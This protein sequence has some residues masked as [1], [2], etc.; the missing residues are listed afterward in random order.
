MIPQTPY[1]AFLSIGEHA[2]D[3]SSYR[4]Y[5]TPIVLDADRGRDNF[6]AGRDK[7]E[8]LLNEICCQTVEVEDELL[9]FGCLVS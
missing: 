7:L 8:S 6:M 5:R 3:G 4:I 9:S 2:M 1:R